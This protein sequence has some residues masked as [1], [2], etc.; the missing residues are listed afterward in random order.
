MAKLVRHDARPE[1]GF[2]LVEV[3]VAMLIGMIGLIG[4]VAI[5][6]SMLMAGKASND[7]SIAMRLATQQLEEFSSRTTQAGTPNLDELAPVA[8]Q[9]GGA[10]MWAF[11]YVDEMGRASGAPELVSTTTEDD[12]PTPTTVDTPVFR[13]RRQW[14]VVNRGVTLPYTISVK[15]RY[16]LDSTTPR[17][18]RL[19]VE[20][21]KTW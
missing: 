9:T 18:I 7:A 17:V 1:R 3:M 11:E 15:V 5:Q 2:T 10:N 12:D 8:A 4:T 21:N 13:W 19:D 14:L 16:N 20:R 6:Q